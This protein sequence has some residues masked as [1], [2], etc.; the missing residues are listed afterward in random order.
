MR[1]ATTRARYRGASTPKASCPAETPRHSASALRAPL[2]RAGQR[3]GISCNDPQGWFDRR[4]GSICHDD[5]LKHLCARVGPTTAA[6]ILKCVCG[7]RLWPSW[8][9]MEGGPVSIAKGPP[10]RRTR[11]THSLE[12]GPGR[13]PRG[14]RQQVELTG[15]WGSLPITAAAGTKRRP[16]NEADASQWFHHMVFADDFILVGKNNSKL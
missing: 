6:G 15:L 13:C 10:P 11:S 9:R 1:C 14:H 3:M 16:R 2:G 7:H 12:C 8:M 4:V 5:L